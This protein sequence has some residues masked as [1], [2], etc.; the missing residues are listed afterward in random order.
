MRLICPHRPSEGLAVSIEGSVAWI[1]DMISAGSSGNEWQHIS[2]SP[3]LQMSL[4]SDPQHDA[5]S[6]GGNLSHLL[7]QPNDIMGSRTSLL[8]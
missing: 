5:C 8:I 1:S 6:E 4:S 2:G 7:L 3:A